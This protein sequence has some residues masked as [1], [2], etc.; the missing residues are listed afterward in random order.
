MYQGGPVRLVVVA[1]GS[2]RPTSRPEA[3]AVRVGA[4]AESVADLASPQQHF[5]P[6]PYEGRTVPFRDVGRRCLGELALR[7][8]G[9]VE[10]GAGWAGGARRRTE[11]QP[12]PEHH[13]L[14]A[15]PGRHRGDGQGKRR[16]GKR[17]P[18]I[19]A[20]SVAGHRRA[21]GA[22]SDRH[23]AITSPDI[24][25]SPSCRGIRWQAPSGVGLGVV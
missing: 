13:D 8:G 9:P 6:G 4:D 15:G 2:T 22:G 3:D 19:K 1:S 12:T 16:A 17:L 7:A 14:A 18:A 20:W 10:G 23:D 25:N 11:P 5:C 24:G 21:A